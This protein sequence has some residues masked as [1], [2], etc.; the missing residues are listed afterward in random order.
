MLLE[1]ALWALVLVYATVVLTVIYVMLRLLW[2]GVQQGLRQ[3]RASSGG[4]LGRKWHGPRAAPARLLG[5]G[6]GGVGEGRQALGAQPVSDAREYSGYLFGRVCAIQPECD[7]DGQPR[8]YLAQ[9][10][11]RNVRGL[12]LHR[13]GAG[14]FCKFR[15]SENLEAGGVYLLTVNGLVWYVGE[16]QN[17]SLRFNTGY[18]HISPR[19]CFEGGQSTNCKVNHQVLEAA[20][21]GQRVELWF[22]ETANRHAVE[23]RLVADLAPPWNSQ[24]KR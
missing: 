1:L 11:Y 6:R 10:G 9:G 22:H 16:C 4:A 18:G 13:Y 21:R 12:R 20:K 2:A 3:A 24:G 23:A 19:N 5:S 14:P 17:L 7:R 8:Q 15:I